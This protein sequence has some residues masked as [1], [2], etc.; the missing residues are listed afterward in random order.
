MVCRETE[1]A[2]RGFSLDADDDENTVGIR[3]IVQRK[4]IFYKKIKNI[5][6][7]ATTSYYLQAIHSEMGHLRAALEGRLVAVE[8]EE[9][10]E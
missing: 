9:E 5:S 6:F 10:S 7:I 1:G 2:T 4:N 8:P 3:S